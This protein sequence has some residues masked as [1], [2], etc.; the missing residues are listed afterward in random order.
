MKFLKWLAT[1]AFVVALTNAG[2]AQ[3]DQGK[4]SGTVR[5]QTGGFVANATVTVKN[6]R[7]AETRTSASTDRGLFLVTGLKPSM[8]TI[9]VEKTGL[10]PLEYTGM[11][12][13]VG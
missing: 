7:T 6:E 13:G 12:L 4:V 1:A 3:T 10:A 8:Y 5:D 2:M 11:T 9:R